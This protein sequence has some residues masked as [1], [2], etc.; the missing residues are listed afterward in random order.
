LVFS[1]YQQYQQEGESFKPRFIKI[2][3]AGGSD[4]P[5][6]TLEEAG[7][8]ISKAEFWQGGYDV[9]SNMIDQLEAMPVKVL[10][11]GK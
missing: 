6:R 8:D 3:S 2:L 5:A 1:L 11:Q 10:E 9:L 7:I 4:A